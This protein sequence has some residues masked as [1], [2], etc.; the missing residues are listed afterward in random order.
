MIFLWGLFTATATTGSARAEGAC[1]E[2]SPPDPEEEGD[3]EPHLNLQA[4]YEWDSNIRRTPKTVGGAIP[5]TLLRL[6]TEAGIRYGAQDRLSF[7]L[8]YEGG[9]KRYLENPDSNLTI[10]L[11]TPQASWADAAEAVGIYFPVKI[12]ST[13]SRQGEYLILSPSANW[14]HGWN[15]RWT[16]SLGGSWQSIDLRNR[17]APSG[18]PEFTRFLEEISNRQYDSQA[19][20]AETG[21][22]RRFSEDRF[23]QVEYAQEWRRYPDFVLRPKTAEPG[24]DT[25]GF[26]SRNDRA[27]RLKIS[28]EFFDEGLQCLWRGQVLYTHSDSSLPG[29]GYEDVRVGLH[30]AAPLVSSL[31][32]TVA[33]Q[34]DWRRYDVSNSQQIDFNL[35]EYLWS[36]RESDQLSSVSIQLAWQATPLISLESRFHYDFQSHYYRRTVIDAGLAAQF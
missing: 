28:G 22:I 7:G 6:F 34:L 10:H 30:G 35:R 14:M 36:E 16:A 5:D 20:I 2:E 32:L 11:I 13:Q 3:W 4:D 9:L 21:L 33:G 27:S 25:L 23:L 12:K 17:I 19:W 29:Y 31:Y 24:N 26:G 15:A 8:D 18:A 1:A